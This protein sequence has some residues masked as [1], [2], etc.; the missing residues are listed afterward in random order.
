MNIL[1]N[2]ERAGP[3]RVKAGRLESLV[4][5]CAERNSVLFRIAPLDAVDTQSWLQALAATLALPAHFGNNFDALYD[6][7]CD[8]T[9][10][11]QT[12]CVLLISNITA[13]SEE[14]SDTLI[15]VLQAASDEWRSEG[16]A[17]WALFDTPGLDLDM[18]PQK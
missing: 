3:Y 15:A 7:L 16:R 4:S 13:L 8:K 14:A 1:A 18:L 9:V 11:P 2:I 17:L 12:T 6:C 5:E 10:M